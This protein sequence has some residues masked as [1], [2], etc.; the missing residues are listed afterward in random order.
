MTQNL[1]NSQGSKTGFWSIK[2]SGISIPVY[3]IMMIILKVFL[4]MLLTTPLQR[5]ILITNNL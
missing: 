3:I 2:I 4:I 5:L 1:D